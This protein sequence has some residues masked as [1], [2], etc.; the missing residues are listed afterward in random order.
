MKNLFK[1]L[2]TL[3]LQLISAAF[4]CTAVSFGL[5]FFESNMFKNPSWTN[6][7]NSVV[8]FIFLLLSTKLCYLFITNKDKE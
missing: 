1:I 2:K 8:P 3:L 6:F 4:L 7:I 5:L